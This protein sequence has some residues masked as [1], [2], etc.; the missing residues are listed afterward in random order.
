MLLGDGNNMVHIFSCA[1]DSTPYLCESLI[2]LV[3]DRGEIKQARKPQRYGGVTRKFKI[4]F[5]LSIYVKTFNSFKLKFYF[6]LQPSK[7][8]R[9]ATSK[10]KSGES[11]QQ[12]SS[13]QSLLPIF[14][15][16]FVKNVFNNS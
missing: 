15:T 8:L 14:V 5:L 6:L 3:G 1:S 16:M 10:K 11:L 13:N 2:G 4:A 9:C 7:S 12:L